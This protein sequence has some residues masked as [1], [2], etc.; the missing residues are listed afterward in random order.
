MIESIAQILLI[1]S[2]LQLTDMPNTRCL[3]TGYSGYN[4]LRLS[5]HSV[6]D[7]L[8]WKWR[9]YIDQFFQRPWG[10]VLEDVVGSL[11]EPFRVQI[12]KTGIVMLKRNF[13]RDGFLARLQQAVEPAQH[14]HG[15]ND[16]TVLAAHIDVAQTVVGDR[17]D[18][19]NNL[20]VSEKIQQM[21]LLKSAVNRIYRTLA[22][23]IQ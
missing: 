15:E 23:Y 22:I 10:G 1:V 2:I 18:E 4:Y 14:K 12:G 16:I 8:E 6:S 20:I 7:I 9:P 17:P 3:M 19:R 5:V 13:F 11:F 21:C